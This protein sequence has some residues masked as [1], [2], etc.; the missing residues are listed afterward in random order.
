[1]NDYRDIIILCVRR[2][3]E[4]TDAAHVTTATR[5]YRNYDRRQDQTAAAVAA[6]VIAPSQV[7]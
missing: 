2:H 7:E 6:A 4:V 5:L 1:M 3:S